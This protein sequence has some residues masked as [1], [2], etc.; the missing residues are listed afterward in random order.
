MAERVNASADQI[1]LAVFFD[2]DGT[3]LQT[4]YVALPAAVDAFEQLK[5]EGLYEGDIPTREQI[6]NVFGMTVEQIWNT[7]MPGSSQEAKE[8]ANALMLRY[9]VERLKRKEGKLY[10][11]VTDVLQKLAERNIPL[12]VV[13][14]GEEAYIDA[15]VE[16]TGL[17]GLFTDLYSAGRFQTKT[18]NDLVAKLLADYR[19]KRAVM[20]GD[21]HSDIEAGNSNGLYTIACDFGFAT[22]GELDGADRCITAFSEVLSVVDQYAKNL[23]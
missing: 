6:L 19:I 16:N 7:L 22:E 5:R 21:R 10:E 15:V 23:K 9:E 20:V 14:N 2:M 13:S 12:F 4:E 11:Q 17:S 3:L 18:K 8:K 1:D